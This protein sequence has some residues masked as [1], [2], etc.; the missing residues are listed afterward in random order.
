MSSPNRGAPHWAIRLA[1]GTG[2]SVASGVLEVRG[3]CQRGATP[4]SIEQSSM[5]VSREASNA[6][7]A[8][9]LTEVLGGTGLVYA[10]G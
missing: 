10:V 3:N 6:I 4:V 2:D 8:A 5:N 7:S 1:S 9:S